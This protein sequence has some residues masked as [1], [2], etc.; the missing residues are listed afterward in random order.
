MTEMSREEIEQF[1]QQPRHAV[2][3]TNPADGPPHLTPVW[4]LYERR[5]IYLGIERRSVKYRN[6]TRDNRISI[7]VDA[8][9]PDGRTVMAYGRAEIEETG[10]PEVDD[11]MWRLTRHYHKTEEEAREYKES[12]SDLDFVLV[13]MTLSKVITQDFNE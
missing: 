12:V 7:C 9:H 4:F 6:L 8:G 2:V 3:G 1:L 11:I 10:T 5:R 13:S